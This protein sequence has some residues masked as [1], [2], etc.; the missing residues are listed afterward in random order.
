MMD[1]SRDI[2]SNLKHPAFFA[3]RFRLMAVLAVVTHLG[4]ATK[5]Y[6]GPF[7]AW[8]NDSLGGVLY[9][10]FWCLVAAFFLP[11]AKTAIIAFWVF[12]VTC[13]LEILQLWHPSVLQMIRS[14]FLGKTLI[15]TSFA[16]LDIPHY[17][18]GCLLGWLLVNRLK[19]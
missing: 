8:V 4:F 6:R 19:R 14:T 17:F 7:H 12:I 13:I 3:F 11:K 18:V 9:E 10:I 5:F 1:A 16:W 2:M 15:G